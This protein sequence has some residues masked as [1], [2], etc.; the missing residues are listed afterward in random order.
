MQRPTGPGRYVGSYIYPKP[1]SFM[2]LHCIQVLIEYPWQNNDVVCGGSLIG[3]RWVLTAAHCTHSRMFWY[4]HGELRVRA[5]VYNR[6]NFDLKQQVL[7]IAKIITHPKYQWDNP[8]Y[9]VALLQLKNAARMTDLVGTICLP[10]SSSSNVPAGTKCVA[11]GWGHTKLGDSQLPEL[12]QEVV[13]PIVSRRHCNRPAAY[14]KLL[15]KHTL[16]AG[17]D[18]GGKDTCHN[19]SGGPLSCYERNKW[20]LHGITN[21]GIKCALPNKYGVYAQVSKYVQWIMK[22]MSAK[23]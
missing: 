5:G 8:N 4:N 12:L 16:C 10:E 18:E 2:F 13:L 6:S 22:E 1:I 20:V 21:S 15:P 9:D 17:Y 3:R 11:T 14:N 23:S 19:D 7:K